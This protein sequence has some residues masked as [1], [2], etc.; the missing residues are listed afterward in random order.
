MFTL[1]HFQE[2]VITAGDEFVAD[3]F[4]ITCGDA[5][6]KVMVP[7]TVKARAG[8]NP[9]AYLAFELSKGFADMANFLNKEANKHD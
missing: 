9:D 6:R 2:Q 7:D 4:F 5:R 8:M 1:K 3:S